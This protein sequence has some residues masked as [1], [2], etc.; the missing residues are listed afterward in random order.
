MELKDLASDLVLAPLAVSPFTCQDLARP[1]LWLRGLALEGNQKKEENGN[2][3]VV[4]PLPLPQVLILGSW[5]RVPHGASRRERREP[6]SP[7]ACV[8]ASLSVSLGSKYTKSKTKQNPTT[9]QPVTG[10]AQR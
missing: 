6:A 3:S 8:F 2:I 7:S 1:P 9:Q 5:D 10:T 4:E